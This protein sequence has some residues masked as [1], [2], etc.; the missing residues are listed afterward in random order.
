MILVLQITLYLCVGPPSLPRLV[1]VVDA[2]THTLTIEW[3]VP[4]TDYGLPILSYH[5]ERFD[6]IKKKW[7]RV[8]STEP[9]VT[10]CRVANLEMGHKY[11]IRVFAVNKLGRS[12]P[13]TTDGPVALLRLPGE[14]SMPIPITANANCLRFGKSPPCCN[15]SAS[16]YADNFALFLLLD[17]VNYVST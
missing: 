10:V 2:T 12:K 14:P 13:S 8:G 3:D 5:V 1:R 7:L 17:P 16:L 9:P 15:L 4:E 6:F 11:K